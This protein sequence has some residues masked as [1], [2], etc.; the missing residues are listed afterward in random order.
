M[1]ELLPCMYGRRTTYVLATA[2]TRKFFLQ[3][4][5]TTATLPDSQRVRRCRFVA[6]VTDSGKKRNFYMRFFNVHAR[7]FLIM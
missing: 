4:T 3:K 6:V 7:V 1:T 2:T 5:V